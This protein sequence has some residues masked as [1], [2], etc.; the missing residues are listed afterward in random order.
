MYAVV[1]RDGACFWLCSLHA[2]CPS[3]LDGVGEPANHPPFIN[4]HAELGGRL[5][6]CRSP[7]SGVIA[8]CQNYLVTFHRAK[9]GRNFLL[10][11]H[12][13]SPIDQLLA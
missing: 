7:H 2:F 1:R 13:I 5:T 9:I 3:R 4:I 12:S 6:E 10:F 8:T 11:W